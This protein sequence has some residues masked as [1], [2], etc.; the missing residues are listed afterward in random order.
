MSNEEDM[1]YIPDNNELLEQL[2]DKSQSLQM[3]LIY[4]DRL[5]EILKGLT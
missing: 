4:I 5:I 2:I 3:E 1:T